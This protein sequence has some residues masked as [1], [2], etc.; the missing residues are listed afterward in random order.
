M[1]IEG[2]WK[3]AAQSPQAT[4]VVESDG[5]HVTFQALSET[6]NR[7]SNAL[8]AAD[9]RTGDRIAVIAANSSSVLAII[10]GASQIGVYYTLINTHLSPTETQGI[11]QD[12]APAV[13]IID[14]PAETAL[15]S[16]LRE[17]PTA[18]LSI[19]LDPGTSLT[20]FRAWNS[21]HPATPPSRRTAGAPMF[22]TSG[23]SGQPKGVQ[24]Q[25]SHGPPE[26]TLPALLELLT[27]HGIPADQAHEGGVHL[28]ASPLHHAAPMYR[29][30]LAL[31]LGHAVVVMDKFDARRSLELIEEHRVTWTQVVPT[32]M[33]RWMALPAA[34]RASFDV[35][36][37]QWVIHA[38]APCPV[39]LKRQVLAWLGPVLHEYYSSTEGGG[40]AIGPH[41]WLT[42]Q[43][44]VGRAWPGADI[45]ILDDEHRPVPPGQ[46]GNI[47]FLS[48]RGFK[49]RNDPAKTSAAR[50][51]DYVTVGDLGRLDADGYLYIAD[52]RSD[53]ILRGGVNIYPA[54][55]E[56]VLMRC[57]GVEDAAVI[58]IPD[59]DLGQVVHAVVQPARHADPKEM[60]EALH[61]HCA[62]FLGSHK[63]P[64][65]LEFRAELPRSESGKLIRR[66]LRDQH[67]PRAS[68]PC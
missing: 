31:H 66:I 35:S 14:R 25:L 22:Y 7:V 44:S 53:L 26:A 60:A 67:Q 55:I 8:L 52:R 32:M 39:E 10:L 28:L 24:P 5:T 15:E 68:W 49:Y 1:S 63:H 43:G 16:L 64:R 17:L 4:A 3:H 18:V 50:H 58:G 12:A 20:S 38:A 42:H 11:L 21:H 59:A 46:V 23:T 37:L 57:P 29:A 45:A 27:R 6:S 33:H 56:A 54:E 51:G 41:E 30:L 9:L 48:R 61:D 65:S 36:S 47:Y 40:T 34:E 62:A 13:V 2:F 19:S